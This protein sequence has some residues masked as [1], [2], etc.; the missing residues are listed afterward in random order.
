MSTPSRRRHA[1]FCAPISRWAPPQFGSSAGWPVSGAWAA[2]ASWPWRNGAAA[3]WPARPK[4]QSHRRYMS[5]YPR[6]T[7][8]PAR[9]A[10]RWSRPVGRRIRPCT[11]A[12]AGWSDGSR[13]RHARSRSMRSS[14][15][16][17][18]NIFCMRWAG[19]WPM[20]TW[21]PRVEPL[22]SAPVL[23]GCLT[24]GCG[25]RHV[26]PRRV[27][28]KTTKRFC[29][30][31]NTRRAASD[32]VRS[33]WISRKGQAFSFPHGGSDGPISAHQDTDEHHCHAP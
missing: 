33:R 29:A 32:A 8:Q 10:E 22:R 18:R 25:Q 9:P 26:W 27:S 7:I 5:P 2:P 4:L 17:T 14:M 31:R 20:F 19:N 1:S 28:S 15:P 16:R 13:P 6:L 3:L 23:S 12:S 21:A 30:A 11:S 24:I